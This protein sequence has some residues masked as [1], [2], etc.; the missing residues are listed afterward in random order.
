MSN[1]LSVT[2]LSVTF[3]KPRG[4]FL[5]EVSRPVSECSLD[6]APGEFVAVVGESGAGKSLLAH[7]IMG[8]L[9]PDAT[10]SGD[11]SF[12]GS[13]L[14][15]AHLRLVRGRDLQFIPQS[16]N[17]LDPTMTA[18]RFVGDSERLAA[19]G[20]TDLAGRYP[21]E[22]SGGQ[23]RRVLLATVAA[24]TAA[25]PQLVI[26]DEPTPGID[27]ASLAQVRETFA[28]LH[29]EGAAILLITHDFPLTMELADR[30]A[31]FK[32]GR[33]IDTFAPSQLVD[34]VSTVDEYS[35]A[36]WSSQPINWAVNA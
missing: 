12:N 27:S 24:G 21:H 34:G 9:P 29:E 28:S 33:I 7:A 32:G 30:I 2:D 11:V 22:L 5:H 1:V 35:R 23:L 17:S 26:A 3:T 20:V 19:Y 31:V 10:V 8:T 18:G 25:A 4:L 14:N 16:V 13:L 6:I 36:L 15:D